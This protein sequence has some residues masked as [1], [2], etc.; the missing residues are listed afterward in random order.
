[1]KFFL[2]RLFDSMTKMLQKEVKG[3]KED[4]GYILESPTAVQVF[5]VRRG[6]VFCLSVRKI[7][8][9]SLGTI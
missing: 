5:R 2:Q 9:D 4:L 8:F 3:R 6:S 1:M 7:N